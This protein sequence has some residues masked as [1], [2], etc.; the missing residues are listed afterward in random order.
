M[1]SWTFETYEKDNVYAEYRW[2]KSGG[3]EVFVGKTY[4]GISYP[5]IFHNTYATK[6]SAKR[7]FKRQI[8]RLE[9]ENN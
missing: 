4:N 7:A 1:S 3:Y 9:N 5:N 2:N 8:R 6:E